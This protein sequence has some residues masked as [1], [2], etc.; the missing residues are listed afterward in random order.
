MYSVGSMDPDGMLKGAATRLRNSHAKR[1][2][3]STKRASEPALSFF[4]PPTGLVPLRRDVRVAIAACFR[5]RG[6][7]QA[8]VA[9]CPPVIMCG[10]GAAIAPLAA[11][12][13]VRGPARPAREIQ[14]RGLRGLLRLGENA[15]RFGAS[16]RF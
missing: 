16:L 15:S 6:R 2:T 5:R 10:G 8:G 4:C 14:L 9:N 13:A 3:V 12:R 11:R 7:G 1:A